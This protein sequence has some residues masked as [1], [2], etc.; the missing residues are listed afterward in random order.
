MSLFLRK[1]RK[2]R[3]MH[4]TVRYKKA[5]YKEVIIIKV[6]TASIPTMEFSDV[7]SV[8]IRVSP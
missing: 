6:R 3:E 7:L 1:N 4:D 5:C 8:A 2:E